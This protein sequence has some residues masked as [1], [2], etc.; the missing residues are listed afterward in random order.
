MLFFNVQVRGDR[1]G[2]RPRGSIRVV[3]GADAQRLWPRRRRRDG[4]K[5]AVVLSMGAIGIRTESGTRAFC[6]NPKYTPF[7]HTHASLQ[8][9][10]E[11]EHLANR[12]R[13]R[14]LRSST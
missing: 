7:H 6:R 13:P 14:R 3:R 1:S 4:V 11:G 8:S 10:R 12:T 2:Q 9:D 5:G